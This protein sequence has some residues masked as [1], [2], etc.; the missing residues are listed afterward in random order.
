MLDHEA[1][2]R[3]ACAFANRGWLV[4]GGPAV[5]VTRAE[6]GGAELSLLCDPFHV[7][8][9]EGDPRV[10]TEWIAEATEIFTLATDGAVP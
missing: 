10:V 4:D 8:R 6:E 3:V 1:R 5:R 2:I 9:A 7:W